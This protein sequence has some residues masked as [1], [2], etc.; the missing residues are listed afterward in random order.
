MNSSETLLKFIQDSEDRR[1]GS[2]IQV[3]DTQK[4]LKDIKESAK[5]YEKLANHFAVIHQTC[6][7]ISS[8]CPLISVTL[9]SLRKMLT[10]LLHHQ[11]SAKFS[12]SRTSLPAYILHLQQFASLKV[13]K[14]ISP[15]LFPHQQLLFPLLLS[16]TSTLR[17]GLDT[18]LVDAL[19]KP[20]LYPLLEVLHDGQYVA[21]TGDPVDNMILL[22][23]ACLVH[24]KN[25]YDLL[26]SLKDNLSHWKEYF[27]VS[28]TCMSVHV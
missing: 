16:L 15:S 12:L 9:D 18:N 21:N 10:H 25:F 22:N 4:G 1:S 5:P 6:K 2:L 14:S 26:M 13:H 3:Q 20:M 11:D 8:V 23:S 19:T 17:K 7:R 27:E 24:L 28:Y